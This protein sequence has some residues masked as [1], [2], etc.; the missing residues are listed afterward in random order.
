MTRRTWIY[1]CLACLPGLAL[2]AGQTT[3]TLEPQPGPVPVVH[4]VEQVDPTVALVHLVSPELRH[5]VLELGDGLSADLR[6]GR[7]AEAGATLAQDTELAAQKPGSHAFATTYALVQAGEAAS[8]EVWLEALRAADDVPDGYQQWLVGVV[9]AETGHPDAALDA[10]GDV[11]L[12]LEVGPEAAL[13]RVD[14]YEAMERPEEAMAALFA[15]A[16]SGRDHQVVGEAMVRAAA[17]LGVDSDR[18]YAFA[19]EAW[20]LWPKTPVAEQAQV[21]L[22]TVVPGPT[23]REVARRAE[24]LMK[25]S[26]YNTALAE[27]D[28]VKGK[29]EKGTV[30][31]C[32]LAF[33]RGRSASKR[34]R[35]TQS[36]AEFANIGTDCADVPGEYGYT[37]LYLHGKALWK[38][39][40]Y[41]DAALVFAQI[42]QLYPQ[43]SFADD[44]YNEAGI[45]FNEAGDPEAARAAWGAALVDFQDGDMTP[46]AGWRLA[47]SLY[48]DGN[49]DDAREVASAL[50]E[51][52]SDLDRVHVAAGRYWSA[53]WAAWPNPGDP[54][55]LTSD[56]ARVQ[57]AIEG[58][59]ELC[60]RQP[61]SF[62]GL[63]AWSRLAELDAK[64][65]DNLKRP[66]EWSD[67][68]DSRPWEIRTEMMDDPNFSAGVGLVRHGLLKPALAEWANVALEIHPDEAAWMVELRTEA[69]DWLLAHDWGRKWWRDNAPEAMGDDAAQVLRVTYPDRYWDEVQVAAEGDRYEARLLH[70]L[71]REESNFNA[72]IR[73]HAGAVGLAQLLPSTAK[74]VAGWLRVSYADSHLS[75]PDRNLKLGARYLDALVKQ[76]SGSPYL[77]LAAYNAG[78]G[79]VDR[80]LSE[81]GN[82][83]TDEFVERIP[84]RETRGYVK[85]VM[86]SWQIMR[87][88]FD[89]ESAPFADLSKFNHES[90]PENEP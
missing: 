5:R 67:G 81:W 25:R 32:R 18:G 43:S 61:H 30:D 22:N 11:P 2:L 19:R 65:A 47:W 49:T 58:L 29:A 33:V 55:T 57:Q 68:S 63:L 21:L 36:L 89:E 38:L 23:W 7:Y 12:A 14:L 82:V 3:V 46:E 42:P 27:T 62:Y 51:L 37:G 54:R 10:L 88:Q 48:L 85:R 8:A 34:G 39:K 75:E 87:W 41:K 78:G 9:L 72:T 17:K 70:A 52:D 69:G 44:G 79:R 20:V 76:Y 86:G 45:A 60:E 35:L 74:E 77:A 40:L 73:S 26:M 59:T 80:W 15:L 90:R 28:S 16:D 24:R 4:S 6:L 50:G 13:R 71:V 31:G 64:A 66:Q 1:G 53:R 56:P 84:Y 83:P